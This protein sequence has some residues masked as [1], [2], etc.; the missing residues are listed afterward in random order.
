M[1]RTLNPPSGFR[2]GRSARGRQDSTR[3]CFDWDNSSPKAICSS[4][5]RDWRTL[6]VTPPQS[7]GA[8]REPAKVTPRCAPYI[9]VCGVRLQAGIQPKHADRLHR[10]LTALDVASV[11]RGHGC[12]RQLVASVGRR[13]CPSLGRKR[14][15][16]LATHI[17]IRWGRRD[18]CRLPG[19]P[20][21]V[22][23]M[24]F[25][26][27]HPGEVLKDTWATSPLPRPQGV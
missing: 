23:N 9:K 26:P 24:I 13:S 7:S 19:L 27:A 8:P 2:R 21:E 17:L 15:R 22:K 11:P 12:T 10:L 14:Q 4:C 20:L 3:R 25:N 16:Q 5:Q 1:K 6:A 18:L